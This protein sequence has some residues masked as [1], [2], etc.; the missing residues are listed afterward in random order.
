MTGGIAHSGLLEDYQLRLPMFEGPIDVLLR[1]IER[2][3]LEI[4]E[5]S[6]AVVTDQFV[7]YVT[8][9]S[10]VPS[11]VL[12]DFSSLAARLLALKSRSLLPAPETATVE[13]DP[14]DLAARLRAYQVLRERAGVLEQLNSGGERTYARVTTIAGDLDIRDHLVPLSTDHIARAMRR[15]LSRSRRKA[16]SYSTTP[17]ISLG[18]MVQRLL[19]RLP[20]NASSRF[21]ELVGLDSSR[22]ERIVGFIALL[23][24]V[25]RNLIVARQTA[26]F[27]EIEIER[28]DPA[29]GVRSEP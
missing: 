12:A 26:M 28:L 4:T 16:E 27:G 15:W 8:A 17:V 6:L 5:V 25:R 7:E 1:M 21:T 19:Q 14:V 20:G 2:S 18:A 23:T 10:E 9:L 24:L 3:E 11:E 22:S 13:P 29:S